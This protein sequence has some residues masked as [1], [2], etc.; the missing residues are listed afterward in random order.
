MGIIAYTF[1]LAHHS[2]ITHLDAVTCPSADTSAVGCSL[3]ANHLAGK[4]YVLHG[5]NAIG[6]AYDTTA[7]GIACLGGL[8]GHVTVDI[9]QLEGASL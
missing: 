7:C 8:H 9:A 1:Y 3:H 5:E 4:D 2:H 6:L